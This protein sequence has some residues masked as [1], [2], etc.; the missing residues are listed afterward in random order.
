MKKLFAFFIIMFLSVH[1]LFAQKVSTDTLKYPQKCS[2]RDYLYEP[3]YKN[4]SFEPYLFEIKSAKQ[5]QKLISSSKASA[6][7]N[8]EDVTLSI[9]EYA[10]HQW[11]L[12]IGVGRL[13]NEPIL[14]LSYNKKGGS[15]YF[16]LR[17]LSKI[18][19]IGYNAFKS[20]ISFYF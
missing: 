7:L 3:A 8:G 5:D 10:M 20:D 9:D 17:K 18:Y 14:Y 13:D 19:Y 16:K 1:A 12:K 4:K 15:T 6:K 2:L 11:L